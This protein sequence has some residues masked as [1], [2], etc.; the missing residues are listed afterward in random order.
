MYGPGPGATGRGCMGPVSSANT[1]AVWAWHQL[2]PSRVGIAWMDRVDNSV[3]DGRWDLGRPR[4]CLLQDEKQTEYAQSFNAR[5]W[6]TWRCATW[7]LE[8]GYKATW[9][10][11]TG[12]GCLVSSTGAYDGEGG[13]GADVCSAAMESVLEAEHSK[14]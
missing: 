2:L 6:S 9:W 13:N 4:R 1:E 11:G 5:Q 3:G 10:R 14:R 7:I 8:Q 12:S